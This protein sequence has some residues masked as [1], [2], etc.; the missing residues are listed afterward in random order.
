MKSTAYH[1]NPH[2]GCWV[3]L[4]YIWTLLRS[5][6]MQMKSAACLWNPNKRFCVILQSKELF[7][8]CHWNP[9]E[10]CC[11][12]LT[13]KWNRLRT[14]AIYMKVVASQWNQKR[15][16]WVPLQSTGKLLRTIEI[17]LKVVAYRENPNESCCVPLKS[18]WN[19]R[20]ACLIEIR[21]KNIHPWTLSPPV[22]KSQARHTTNIYLHSS[23]FACVGC[24]LL[25]DILHRGLLQKQYS[26]MRRI[27][28]YLMLYFDTI[29]YIVLWCF[30]GIFIT[31]LCFH[32]AICE[33][34]H[35]AA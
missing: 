27:V 22:R 8:A 35:P 30:A 4:E 23:S 31:I 20:H 25:V 7:V 16:C 11:V 19:V 18:R 29:L 3:P 17:Q 9:N 34:L 12:A 13:F 28:Q 26:N 14:T 24:W 1:C 5:I 15:I 6:E 32:V 33:Y 2:E 21:Q 10:S